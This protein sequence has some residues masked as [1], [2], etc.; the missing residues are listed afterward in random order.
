MDAEMEW[1]DSGTS[2]DAS[3]NGFGW[4]MPEGCIARDL[5]LRDPES[6]ANL[7]MWIEEYSTIRLTIW[8]RILKFFGKNK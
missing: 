1:P 8:G 5:D 6:I 7:R 3:W 2:F 4:H